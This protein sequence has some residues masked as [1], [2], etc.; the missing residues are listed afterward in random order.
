MAEFLSRQDRQDPSR[1]VP[2][3]A[4]DQECRADCRESEDKRREHLGHRNLPEVMS[5]N[6]P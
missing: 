3:H 5:A 4:H 2:Q 6:R 1:F